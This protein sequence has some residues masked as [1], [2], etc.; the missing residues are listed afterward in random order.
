MSPDGSQLGVI[1][2][3]TDRVNAKPALGGTYLQNTWE[4]EREK[5]RQW[6]GQVLARIKVDFPLRFQF[7]LQGDFLRCTLN[8]LIPRK[9]DS[10][11]PYMLSGDT[12]SITNDTYAA[13]P[14]SE[15]GLI[16]LV[17]QQLLKLL[18]HELAECFYVDNKRIFDPHPKREP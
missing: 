17:Y 11:N 1:V 14:L 16:E 3:N 13:P 4:E 8:G 9:G 12:F 15:H 2:A 10:S 6:A 18:S 5:W 7:E